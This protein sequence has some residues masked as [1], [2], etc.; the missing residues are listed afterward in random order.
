MREGKQK[1][2]VPPYVSHI[3]RTGQFQA[4]SVLWGPESFGRQNVPV[5]PGSEPGRWVRGPGPGRLSENPGLAG[6]LSFLL[7]S[8]LPGPPLGQP[9]AYPVLLCAGLAPDVVRDGWSSTY[10]TDAEEPGLVPSFLGEP[11]FKLLPRRSLAPLLFICSACL[12]LS[13][14]LF[15]CRLYPRLWLSG[16]GWF[17]QGEG[18]LEGMAYCPRGRATAGR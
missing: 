8:L 6:G 2:W 7:S 17:W 16:V 5:C 12:F 13:F 3:A 11:A 15:W 1:Q 4:F 18:E 10:D 9:L 14:D